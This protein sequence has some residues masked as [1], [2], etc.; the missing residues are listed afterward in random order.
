M[1]IKPSVAEY[2]IP[3]YGTYSTIDQELVAPSKAEHLGYYK[4]EDAT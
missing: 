2:K 4:C 3:R 1:R